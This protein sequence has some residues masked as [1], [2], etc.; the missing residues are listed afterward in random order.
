MTIGEHGALGLRR[1]ALTTW[2][3]AVEENIVFPPYTLSELLETARLVPRFVMLL[4]PHQIHKYACLGFKPVG[5]RPVRP[6]E[7]QCR[8][9][10]FRPGIG[11]CVHH[12]V[13]CELA[14]EGSQ[15][16]ILCTFAP[17]T[18]GGRVIFVDS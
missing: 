7:Q 5:Q 10:R 18:P 15:V 9:R 11:R 12:R 6:R 13:Q 17:A 1:K 3:T 14:V 16:R 2:S 4:G 8:R